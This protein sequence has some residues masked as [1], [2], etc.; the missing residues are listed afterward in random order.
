M[1]QCLA[2]RRPYSYSGGLTLASRAQVAQDRAEWRIGEL[3]IGA[4]E[5]AI[6]GLST[7]PQ[8]SRLAF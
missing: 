8:A 2:G 7:P 1:A 6:S 3:R 5:F 4:R